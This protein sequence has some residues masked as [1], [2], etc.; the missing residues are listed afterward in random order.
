[1]TRNFFGMEI[2]DKVIVYFPTRK[3]RT[4]PPTHDREHNQVNTHYTMKIQLA[5]VCA[6]FCASSLFARH[7]NPM[8]GEATILANPNNVTF[9]LS[10]IFFS[11]SENNILFIDFEAVIDQLIEVNIL[12]GE[13]LMMED[14]VSDLPSNSIYEINLDVIRAGS[15]VIEL[16]TAEGI[17][18]HK[19]IWVE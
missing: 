12:Q 6:L 15:Y 8:L 4:L 7:S 19:N 5:I 1:M 17:V 18:V 13:V 3:S 16:V 9:S 11:D 2:D 10:D 14:D